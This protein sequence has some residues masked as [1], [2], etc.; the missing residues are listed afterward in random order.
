MKVLLEKWGALKAAGFRGW[1][2]YALAMVANGALGFV[3]GLAYATTAILLTLF[4][5]T[6]GL[7]VSVLA[8]ATAEYL[9]YQGFNAGD[10]GAMEWHLVVQTAYLAAPFVALFLPMTSWSLIGS[11]VGVGAMTAALQRAESWAEARCALPPAPVRLH[12]IGSA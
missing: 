9:W 10:V 8:V 7:W 1:G 5:G 4:Y 12:A 2:N 3:R 6:A 11:L